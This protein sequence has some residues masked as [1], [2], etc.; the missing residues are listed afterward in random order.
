MTAA[1]V[2]PG[3][4]LDVFRKAAEDAARIA[5]ESAPGNSVVLSSSPEDAQQVKARFAGAHKDIARARNAA[6]EQQK[7]AKELIEQKKR[8]LDQM[9][10]DANAILVPLQKQM[11]RLQDGIAG[12]N[13]YLGRDE[14]ITVVCEGERAPADEVVIIRQTTLNMDEETAFLAAEE[15]MDFRHIGEF[16]EWLQADQKNIDQILPERKAVAALRP[17]GSWKNYTGD[18]FADAE[19]NKANFTTFWL[20]RNGENLWLTTAP[21]A[22]GDHMVPRANEFTD[23]FIERIGGVTRPMQPG[24][25][26]WVRAEEQADMSTRHYMKVALLLQGLVDRTKVFHPLPEGG[27]S[28]IEQ[29]FYDSGVV[30]VITDDEN[31]L[32][33]VR[34]P[35]DAWLKER[36]EM[37]DT[38]MRVVGTFGW[39]H[40]FRL[41]D[42]KKNYETANVRPQGCQPPDGVYTIKRIQDREFDFSFTF[43]RTDEVWDPYRGYSKPQR[44]ATGKFRAGDR[45]VLPLDAITVPEMEEYLAARS[46]RKHYQS[47]FPLLRAAITFKKQEAAEEKPFRDAL[48]AVLAQTLGHDDM[49]AVGIEADDLIRWYK[50][51]N[52]WHRP[53]D[54]DD[55][56]ASRTILAEHKRRQSSQSENPLSV[57]LEQEPDAMVVARRT[58]DY[59]AVIP[60][61]RRYAEPAAPANVWAT[62][63]TFT[64]TGV[65]KT[66]KSWQMLTRAQVAKWSVIH[67]TAA[68]SS[69]A[70]DPNRDSHL[71]DAEITEFIEAILHAP[72][73][74]TD[75]RT[76]RELQKPHANNPF[77][78]VYTERGFDNDRDEVRATVHLASDSGEHYDREARAIRDKGQLRF[79]LGHESKTRSYRHEAGWLTPTW[80]R[81]HPDHTIWS[82]DQVEATLLAAIHIRAV[83]A[84]AE[85]KLFDRAHTLS[86]K[87]RDAWV[88]QAWLAQKARYVEDFGDDELWDDHKKTLRAPQWPYWPSNSSGNDFLRQMTDR[89]LR[90]GMD[91]HGHSLGDIATRIDGDPIDVPD[92]C[93]A[94]VYPAAPEATK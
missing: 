43:D 82:N 89:A 47:M 45:F 49:D 76:Y 54:A 25:T 32:A 88:E 55:A 58:N 42:D 91:I 50:T 79:F 37:L 17:R 72:Q 5:E 34:Q 12:V 64:G 7:A 39:G 93:V 27:L 84:D 20:V 14:E 56:K 86:M 85:R 67:E 62:I 44:K 78:V 15:G 59:V 81:I 2:Q 60:E 16:V 38:G 21:F 80:G 28:F 66:R 35:F 57:I 3:D 77:R 65:E 70:L 22:V 51:A 23:L 83:A 53:L 71:T 8:E 48:I 24:S 36:T 87:V 69:W 6:L 63:V 26:A 30:R 9:M 46:E 19:L 31:V 18:P 4:A 41:Y 13:L 90:A 11:D 1:N 73:T 40:K 94:L 92:D 75:S 61:A 29:S 10:R 74:L 33:A 52:R 68:W